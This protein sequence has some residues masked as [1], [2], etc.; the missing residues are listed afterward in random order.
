MSDGDEGQV[1][2]AAAETYERFFVPAL[3]GQWPP[4]VIE[5]AGVAP[6]QRVLDVGCG[7]GVLARAASDL[8]GP[9]GRV[10]GVDPNAGMLEVA[11]RSPEVVEWVPGSAEDLP[12]PNGSFDHVVSLFAAM[13][14][15]DRAR[16]MEEMA[17]VVVH[18]GSVTVVTWAELDTAPGYAAM[19]SLFDDLFGPSAARAVTAPFSLGRVPELQALLEE[20]TSHVQVRSV[21]GEARFASIDSWIHT[22]IRG[23]TLADEIDDEQFA[24]LVEAGRDRLRAFADGT[25][26]VTFPVSA[27]VGIGRRSPA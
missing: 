10:V 16:A 25:G 21:S 11:R 22:E 18:G 20:A 26:R 24:E 13:F 19:A 4:R 6:G 3:F 15:R 23:W 5:M 2:V 17:R 27:L 1:V 14:F 7:T 12:F 8:V 9:A